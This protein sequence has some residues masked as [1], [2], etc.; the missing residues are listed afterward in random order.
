M[1]HE[2]PVSFGVSKEKRSLIRSSA[3]THITVP[4]E[5]TRNK[6]AVRLYYTVNQKTWKITPMKVLD[7]KGAT[8]DDKGLKLTDKRE[9]SFKMCNVKSDVAKPKET[10]QFKFVV[11][12]DG[13]PP[14]FEHGENVPEF[15]AVQAE[16][17]S[18][19][20]G[21][22][23]KKKETQEDLQERVSQLEN[24]VKRIP[25]LEQTIQNLHLKLQQASEL[26]EAERNRAARD[27]ENDVTDLA[28]DFESV[29]V[30]WD[31]VTDLDSE[32]LL[33]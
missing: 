24:Q 28:N 18:I 33:L 14:Q 5:C 12:E 25:E 21:G 8:V 16:P 29:T 23:N 20:T 7:P 26:L 4:L 2:L 11:T 9:V 30:N 31:A 17:F 19:E 27:V 15:V 3:L 13:E 10:P 32:A 1:S 6:Y 22:R